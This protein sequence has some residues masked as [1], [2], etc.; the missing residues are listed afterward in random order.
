MDNFGFYGEKADDEEVKDIKG[1]TDEVS[2]YVF[3]DIQYPSICLKED[4]KLPKYKWVAISKLVKQGSVNK[5]ISFYL[6]RNNEVLK[7]GALAGIQIKAFIDI[8]GIENLFG[9]YK[10]DKK[11]EGDRLYILSC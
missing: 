9:F 5:N 3:S 7:A 8:V 2:K 10:K 1:V 11:L 6:I 4:I